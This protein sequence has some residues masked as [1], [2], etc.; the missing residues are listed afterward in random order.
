M[1]L[2]LG[3]DGSDNLDSIAVQL[4][5]ISDKLGINVKCVFRD[6]ELEAR[7]G[8]DAHWIKAVF[9]R[10]KGIMSTRD[11]DDEIEASRKIQADRK[12]AADA[13]YRESKK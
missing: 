4:C 7:P 11:A 3:Q 9:H 1:E 6:V 10:T 5:E 13:G 2:F 12:A 8:T